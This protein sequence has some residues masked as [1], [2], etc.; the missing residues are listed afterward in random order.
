MELEHGYQVTLTVDLQAKGVAQRKVQG[1]GS[2]LSGYL[3]AQDPELGVLYLL[4]KTEQEAAWKVI[5]IFKDSVARV[6]G[7]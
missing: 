4:N 6:E 3:C 1:G 7:Q 2:V 5:V